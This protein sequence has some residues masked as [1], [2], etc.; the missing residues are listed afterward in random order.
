LLTYCVIELNLFSLFIQILVLSHI[1]E[2]ET[3][4]LVASGGLLQGLEPPT[5]KGGYSWALF[6]TAAFMGTS[7]SFSLCLTIVQPFPGRL[8]IGIQAH[9]RIEVGDRLLT[10]PKEDMGPT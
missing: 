1:F 8:S 4:R 9:R 5:V 3:S 7:L 6:Q 10:L 2:N